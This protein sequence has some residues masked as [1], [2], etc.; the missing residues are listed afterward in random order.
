MLMQ[1]NLRLL[2]LRVKLVQAA[3]LTAHFV[4]MNGFEVFVMYH[5][6]NKTQAVPVRV[7]TLPSRSFAIRARS[8]LAQV[9]SQFRP[10]EGQAA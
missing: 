8:I 7:T 4:Q 9:P 1:Q 10:Q 6:G 3:K 5:M 2:L